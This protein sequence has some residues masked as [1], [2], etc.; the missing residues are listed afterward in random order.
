[1]TA[2]HS[3][4][5]RSSRSLPLADRETIIQDFGALME[6]RPPLPTRIEDVSALPHPKATILDAL[7]FEL[8]QGHP[9]HMAEMLRVAAISL[10]QY[11]PGVGREP[12]EML[13]ADISKFPA[14]LAEA[15][16]AAPALSKMRD[17]F[18]EFDKLVQDDL[19]RIISLL[20]KS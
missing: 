11:Q 7:L 15:K 12:L 6:R 8:G 17:R 14:T 9:K 2:W 5:L 3:P 10:A 1:M 13:G 20:D 16:R 19:R 4:N 18:K